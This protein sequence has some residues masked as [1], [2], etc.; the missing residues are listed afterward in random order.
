MKR[1]ANAKDKLI[2]TVKLGFMGMDLPAHDVVRQVV[3]A[4]ACALAEV[5]YELSDADLLDCVETITRTPATIEDVARRIEQ[6]KDEIVR[7]YNEDGRTDC[8]DLAVDYFIE[9]SKMTGRIL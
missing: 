7:C 4:T 1:T 3:F 5:G 2:E 8:A 9:L 6:M